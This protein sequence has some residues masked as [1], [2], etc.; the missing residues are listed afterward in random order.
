MEVF[1][2]EEIPRKE[3]LYASGRREI[4][5]ACKRKRSRGGEGRRR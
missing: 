4:K 2:R 1:V 5:E 3:G